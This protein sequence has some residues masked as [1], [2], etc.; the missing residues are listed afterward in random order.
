M[1]NGSA[2]CA[3]ITDSSAASVG[4]AA[5][6]RWLQQA[7]ADSTVVNIS[8]TVTIDRDVYPFFQNKSEFGRSLAVGLN[9]AGTA[10]PPLPPGGVQLIAAVVSALAVQRTVHTLDTG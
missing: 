4:G 1:L 9:S 5:E 10:L 2:N 8:S 6:R 7:V 3:E